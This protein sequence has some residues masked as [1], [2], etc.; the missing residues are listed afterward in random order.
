MFVSTTVNS[1][2]DAVGG[3]I[4]TGTL[5]ALFSTRA[6]IPSL[7]AGMVGYSFVWSAVKAVLF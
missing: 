6:S 4:G 1:I 7:L 5:E 3:G 2:P